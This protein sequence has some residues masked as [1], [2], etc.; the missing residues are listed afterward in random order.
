MSAQRM[1]CLHQFGSVSECNVVLVLPSTVALYTLQS[2][3]LHPAFEFLSE[4]HRSDY[5]R[6]YFMHFHGGGYTDIKDTTG[7]WRLAFD[8]FERSDKWIAGYP[9]IPGGVAY[10]PLA[11][12][13][14]ELIG[15]C[16]FLCKPRTP[17]TTEW[18]TS[19]IAVLDEKLETLRKYP[20]THPQ[21]CSETSNG[22]Y[23]IA[24]AEMLGTI[25]HRVCYKHKN[26]LQ[27][28]L[29]V[30]KFSNYR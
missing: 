23:P 25:F 22:Q 27:I 7:S 1:N 18:Y 21:D 20:S 28:I 6:T 29:P 24:W 4:T 16:A 13:F 14:K 17:L 12:C 8:V 2:E 9:E 15:C 3:P 5:L 26:K 11:S 19:M 10:P 30:S